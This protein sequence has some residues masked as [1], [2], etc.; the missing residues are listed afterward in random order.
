MV[1]VLLDGASVGDRY[2]DALRN[3]LAHQAI[4]PE[5][6]AFVDGRRRLVEEEHLGLLQQHPSEGDSLLLAG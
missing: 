4:E 1:V 2:D 6:L 3:A 5:L